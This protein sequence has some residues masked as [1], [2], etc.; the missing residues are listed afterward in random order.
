MG[1]LLIILVPASMSG[2]RRRG[3]GW[4]RLA[5]GISSRQLL[6]L[7]WCGNALPRYEKPA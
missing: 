4:N 6:N 3:K 5:T 2:R 7:P 1:F